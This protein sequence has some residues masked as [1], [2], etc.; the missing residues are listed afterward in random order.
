MKSTALTIAGSDPSGGAGIQADLKTFH[1]F[2]VYGQAAITLLTVQNTQNVFDVQVQTPDL[3]VAQIRA[4]LDDMPPKAAKTGA[5]GTAAVVGAVAELAGSFVFPLVVDPVMISKHGAPLMA[6]EAQPALFELLKRATLVMPNL[7]EAAALTGLTV[8][9]RDQM[10]E[11]AKRI[12]GRCGC[13]VLVKGGHLDGIALDLLL[14]DE[15]MLYEYPAERIDTVH[16]H[17]TGCTY[18]AAVTACL[19]VGLPLPQA[20]RAA[21]EFITEAIRTNPGLGH[22]RGPV[23]HHARNPLYNE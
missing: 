11:A 13:A 10:A 18:S 16:T 20:V 2:G 1:Q 8:E 9:T 15:S 19:A 7:H 4:V 22:G 17:G 23:N 14:L 6:A 12:F 5:L 21:K 3:V